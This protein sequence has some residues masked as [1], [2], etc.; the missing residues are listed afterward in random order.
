MVNENETQDP[1]NAGVNIMNGFA[2]DEQNQDGFFKTTRVYLEEAKSKNQLL[3]TSIVDSEQAMDTA[4]ILAKSENTRN[5]I[6]KHENKGKKK[7]PV[8][9]KKDD[10]VD[11]TDMTYAET[12]V[13]KYLEIA[14]SI[15]GI[16]RKEGVGILT[17]NYQPYIDRGSSSFLPRKKG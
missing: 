4:T 3:G 8:N 10:G 14:K 9:K 13:Y 17:G 15:N 12:H 2:L 11:Y 5:R 1:N 6:A 7:D 16:A